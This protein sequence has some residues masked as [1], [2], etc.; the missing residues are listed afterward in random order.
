MKNLK[1]LG[2]SLFL[3]LGL[4]LLVYQG[5][6]MSLKPNYNGVEKLEGLS[7]EVQ[8]FFDKYGIPHIYA[9][10]EEDAFKALGYVHAQD[11]LWQMEVIRRIGAGRLS[12]LFGADLLETDKLFL[13]LGIDAASEK[14]VAQLETNTA[15]FKLSKAYLEGVNSFLLSGPTPVEFYLTGVEKKAFTLKDIYNTVGYM[16]FSFAV[17]QRTDP[18]LSQISKDLGPEYLKDLEIDYNPSTTAIPFKQGTRSAIYW[19]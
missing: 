2:V 17:A 15:V 12:E 9:Q 18:L 16:A 4:L 14:A 19:E 7:E 13:S 6:K 11:R 3:I 8:V 1:R 10:N 5:I